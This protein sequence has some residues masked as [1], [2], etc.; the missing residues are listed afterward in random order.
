[1]ELV[2]VKTSQDYNHLA[3]AMTYLEANGISCTLMNIQ[4][5]SIHILML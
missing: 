2:T 1:M 3:I 5:R 4:A